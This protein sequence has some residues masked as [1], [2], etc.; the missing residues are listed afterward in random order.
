LPG[1]VLPGKVAAQAPGEE[2]NPSA[3]TP[4]HPLP[5]PAP[6]FGWRFSPEVSVPS[7]CR[8][9]SDMQMGGE[10]TVRLHSSPCKKNKTKQNKKIHLFGG[11]WDLVNLGMMSRFWGGETVMP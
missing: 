7:P 10:T 5:P 11:L 2:L 4:A 3:H 6:H 8:G 9:S 1:H